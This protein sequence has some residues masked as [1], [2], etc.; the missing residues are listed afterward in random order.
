MAR[1]KCAGYSLIESLPTTAEGVEHWRGE[2]DDGVADIY[3]GEARLRD[4][5]S[6]LPKWG[7]FA[8]F[9]IGEDGDGVYLIVPG[10]LARTLVDLGSE[11]IPD[12]AMG[13]ALHIATAVAELHERGGAHGGLHPEH[14]GVDAS[15]RL[16]IRPYLG[17]VAIAEPDPEASAQ[18]TDCLQCAALLEGLQIDRL[19]D[20]SISLVSRG[21]QREVAR[22]RI[23]P[24]RAVRQ[25][26]SAV[27]HRL[28]D[29]EV[30]IAEA[31]GAGWGLDDTPWEIR[32]DETA[33]LFVEVA[34]D[35][36]ED[37]EIPEVERVAA[38]EAAEEAAEAERI[39][40]EEAAE[41][42]RI[43]AE[44]AAE[45]ERVAA[46]EASEAERIAAEEA[47][48]AERIAAEEAAEAERIAAEEAAEAE[49]TAAEEAAEAERTAAE[50]AAE[51]ERVAAEEA[52]AE[53]ERIAAEEAAAAEAERVAS[54]AETRT[55]PEK[56]PATSEPMQSS[57]RATSAP[58]SPA[59]TAE[60]ALS[61]EL[62][63]TTD[64]VPRWLGAR[65]VTNTSAREEELGLGKWTE[66]SNSVRD[67]TLE[68]D[69]APVRE[70]EIEEAGLPWMRLIVGVGLLVVFGW[71]FFGDSAEGEV[72]QASEQA[73]RTTVVQPDI[74]RVT[75]DTQPPGA[76]VY[77]EGVDYGLAPTAVPVPTDA[78]THELCV[79]YKGTRTCRS[80]TGE[81]L[82]FEDP[83]RFI[84]G[85]E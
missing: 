64:A 56:Q 17:G 15:G 62:P 31:L 18:A 40:A 35:D 55:E 49:R 11:E 48:E 6:S 46:E 77:L 19:D 67:F 47:A 69:S 51:A 3:L 65:G 13:V 28:S 27:L 29:W 45:A 83:Y 78:Q 16:V 75:V 52:S 70:L 85:G 38:E 58:A 12:V 81:A 39:A 80:L 79:I 37:S 66:V 57:S 54:M 82:A 36:S 84:I 2:S 8:K 44:E 72:N 9:T 5:A 76:R 20:S 24:G 33:P 32:A 50:E 23:Q 60:D 30:A 7:P 73:P 43:A 41:A 21:L 4:R 53:A 42:E 74:P 26:L 25:S 68:M 71:Y 59:D 63:S 1:K 14:V 22:R 10:A 61:T 34:E